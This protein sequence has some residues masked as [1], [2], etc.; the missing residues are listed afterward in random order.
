[1]HRHSCLPNPA[2]PRAARF[3]LRAPLALWLGGALSSLSVAQ[4]ANPLVEAGPR[5]V[6]VL[7]VLLAGVGVLLV[8]AAVLAFAVREIRRE[9][10]ERRRTFTYR[11]RGPG[12]APRT[13]SHR[14]D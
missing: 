1:M 7:L 2:R 8:A 12:G 9:G 11:R 6:E 13:A 14:S 4:A 5:N 10:A 3:R